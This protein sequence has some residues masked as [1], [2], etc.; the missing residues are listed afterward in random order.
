MYENVTYDVVLQR[1]LDRIS[2]SMDKREGSLIFDTCSATAIE[3]QILYL[4][5]DY[6]I[7]NSYGDTAAR[8]YLILLCK[9]RGILPEAAT[10]AVLKGIFKPDTVDVTG[11][12]FNVS[13]V[14]YTVTEKIEP[15]IYKV[16]CENTGITG[17][18]FLGTMTP[19]NYIDGLKTAVLTEVL[20][21]GE[22]EEDTEHL[23]QR[24]LQSFEEQAFG[25]NRA[26]YIQKVNAIP[27]V[28]VTKVKRAWNSDIRPADMIPGDKVST[29]YE[30][31]KN[32]LN[33]EVAQWLSAVYA[34]AVRKKLTVGGTVLLTVANSL[35]YG[36]VS[37]TLLNEIQTAVDPVQNA[38][39]G[40]GL[41]PIGHIVTVKSVE[42]IEITISSSITCDNGY[43]L[44]D[45]KDYIKKSVSAYLLEL[46]K[47]WKDVEHIIVRISQIESAILSV[48]GIL[49]VENTT[50]NGS[51]TNLTLEENEV[52]VFGGVSI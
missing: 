18:Q 22:D 25:G 38:G 35:D 45:I 28:S 24:Y 23:R 40:Y 19:I 29:W 30:S 39:E 12:R 8:E 13:E 5:L 47:E 27:G 10:H 21:P 48:K 7:E 46:R 4:Q 44:E 42:E 37:D 31:V 26:D 16:Q 43:V 50:L 34:A 11:Q 36:K 6:L 51:V 3:L 32:E 1:M 41:A 33:E 14:N 52:P 2:S 15:G 49:D 20:I 17:N 9:D